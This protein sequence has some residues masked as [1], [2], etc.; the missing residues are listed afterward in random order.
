M[1]QKPDFKETLSLPQT[2]FKM[3]A[4]LPQ[5]E[6]AVTEGRPGHGHLAAARAGQILDRHAIVVCVPERHEARP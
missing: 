3:K 5:R 1:S 2:S 6:P 4:N